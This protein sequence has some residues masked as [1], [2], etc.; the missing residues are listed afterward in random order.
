MYVEVKQQSGSTKSYVYIS[1]NGWYAKGYYYPAYQSKTVIGEDGIIVA[2]NGEQYFMVDNSGSEQKIYVQGLGESGSSGQ[3]IKK[4]GAYKDFGNKLRDFLHTY[5]K[6]TA[7]NGGFSTALD[8]IVD[9]LPDD[10]F[11]TSV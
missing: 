8:G 2:Q 4:K 11:I 9:A 10:I 3:L 1:T 5:I 7:K 6:D